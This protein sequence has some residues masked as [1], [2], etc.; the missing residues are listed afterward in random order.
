MGG[1]GQTSQLTLALNPGQTEEGPWGWGGGGCVSSGSS[2]RCS[3]WW[4]RDYLPWSELLLER[5]KTPY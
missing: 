3:G 5:P 2:G 4:E 1:G